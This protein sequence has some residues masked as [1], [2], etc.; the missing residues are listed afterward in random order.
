[1][2]QALS[3]KTFSEADLLDVANVVIVPI[4]VTCIG[5]LRALQ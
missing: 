1:M 2:A 3:T 5:T 4:N